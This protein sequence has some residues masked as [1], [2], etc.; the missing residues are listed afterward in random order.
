MYIWV[1]TRTRRGLE[2]GGR[3]SN[4]LDDEPTYLHMGIHMDVHIVTRILEFDMYI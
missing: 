4:R 2:F 1:Y 3:L